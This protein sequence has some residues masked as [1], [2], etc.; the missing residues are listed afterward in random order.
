MVRGHLGRQRRRPT[1]AAARV[2]LTA[3]RKCCQ[4]GVE[5]ESVAVG[6]LV[7]WIWIVSRGRMQ[8]IYRLPVA[9][10]SFTYHGMLA[11]SE[12]TNENIF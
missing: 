8:G 4:G 9:H 3:V 1:A 6:W 2:G 11:L 7:E 12:Q 10:V 5:G